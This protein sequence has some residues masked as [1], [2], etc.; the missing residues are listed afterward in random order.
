M[1]F[2]L[3]PIFS[4]NMVLQRDSEVVVWGDAENDDLIIGKICGQK[5]KT[6]VKN[7]KFRLLFNGLK[8]GG[9]FEM[10]ILSKDQEVVF[11]NILIGE[12]WIAGGQSNMEFN[13]KDS[14]GA[15]K[16]I[17]QA[18][19]PEIRYYNVP[20]IVY[21]NGDEVFPKGIIDTGW[22]VASSE[23]AAYYSAV[24]YHFA[25]NLYNDLKVPIGIVNCNKGGT[26]A[27]SWMNEKYLSEDNELS[28]VYLEQY[29]KAIE[30]LTDEEEDRLTAEFYK[31]Q[32]DYNKREEKY[33]KRYPESSMA[34]LHA[35]IGS[36]P[37]PPPLGRK[38]YQRPCGLYET[39]F[40]KITPFKVRGVVWYQGEE[41]SAKARL[42]KKL[43]HRLIKS[44]R[45][46]LENSE[47][48]FVFVQLPMFN[49]EKLDTWQI[50]RDA[51]L[52]IYKNVKNTSMIVTVDLGEAEDVHPKDK[53]PVGERL[54]L[55][56]RQD[57]YK[58]DIKRHSPIYHDYEIIGNKVK[59]NFDY[60]LPDELIIKDDTE[61]KGFEIYDKNRNLYPAKAC[62]VEDGVIVSSDEVNEP[63]GVAYGWKNY[64]EINLFNNIGLPASPF[65]TL[66]KY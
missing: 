41:D 53:K 48:P 36:V 45:E 50:I 44:W 37:W 25:K 26:S 10:N 18:N 57:V 22:S 65:N 20:D 43:F 64:V 12:V 56:A 54:A 24:A 47:L 35:E 8:A 14:I 40:R 58:E 46:D 15:E 59:I 27:S 51:Q 28:E 38:S 62:I 63:I 16:E 1:G 21:E 19:Y 3:A 23:T 66:S 55:A 29:K 31:S 4:D 32:E 2:K 42:Y 5:V 13:L 39:K 49:D 60:V 33:K 6:H 34:Q 30:N 7:G 61:L 17:E 11:K 52:Y 9:P